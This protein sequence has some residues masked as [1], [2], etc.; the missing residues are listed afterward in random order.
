[1]Y[2]GCFL[3]AAMA[4]TIVAR[5]NCMNLLI[6]RGLTGQGTLQ[7]MTS[8]TMAAVKEDILIVDDDP[9]L[10]RLL[11]RYLVR[12]GYSASSTHTCANAR[13]QIENSP[14]SLVLLDVVLPDSDGLSLL[15]ELR[16]DTA[17]PVILLTGKTDIIDKVV[18]LELGA[19]DYITKPFE[20]RELL[21]RIRTVLRRFSGTVNTEAPSTSSSLTFA[22]WRLD[23]GAQELTSPV[24][25]S[26]SLTTYEFRLLKALAEVAPRVLGR[27]QIL[28][29]VAGRDAMPL[30]RSVDVLIGK[31]R[32]KI[33]KNPKT[34]VIIKTIRGSGYKISAPVSQQ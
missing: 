9:R 22:D 29:V 13:E 15:R 11:E 30:D 25:A 19:D 26:V 31:L 27:D 28:D 21:A 3:V 4:V 7:I 34:P 17:I 12:E 5:Y 23:V 6:N 14:P 24:G 33:E 8:G 32:K 10:C 20:E 1:M 16:S 18:G 2:L